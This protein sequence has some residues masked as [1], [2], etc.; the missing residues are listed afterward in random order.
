[1]KGIAM[2]MS[3]A[4]KAQREADFQAWVDRAVQEGVESGK[5]LERRVKLGDPWAVFITWKQTLP[6]EFSVE[7]E[8]LEKAL[9]KAQK[10]RLRAK[11]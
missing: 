7:V 3:K 6:A 11:R 4:T 1:M 10:V 2:T 8:R 5:E 9:K